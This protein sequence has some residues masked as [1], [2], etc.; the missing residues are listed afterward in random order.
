MK[1]LTML[2]GGLVVMAGCQLEP[3]ANRGP[4]FLRPVG[5]I[6]DTGSSVILGSYQEQ[7]NADQNTTM[8]AAAEVV[9][10]MRL[11]LVSSDTKQIH[12]QFSNGHKVW[13]TAQPKTAT[14]TTLDVRVDPHNEQVCLEVL[15]RIS[16]RL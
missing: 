13:I 8:K 6:A 14:I 15:R 16:E 5:D 9:A 3:G 4:A 7:F 1:L 10:E 2:L 12:A 11:Q